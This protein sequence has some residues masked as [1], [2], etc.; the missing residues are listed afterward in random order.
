[1]EA[2]SPIFATKPV[3]ALELSQVRAELFRLL[4]LFLASEGLSKLIEERN[5]DLTHGS[6]AYLRDE[7]QRQEAMRLLLGTAGTI[8]ILYHDWMATQKNRL[9]D[10]DYIAGQLYRDAKSDAKPEPL[11]LR[12]ACN[13]LLHAD[14]VHFDLAN[15]DDWPRHFLKPIVYLYGTQNGCEWKAALNVIDYVEQAAN[16][17]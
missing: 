4:A 16:V 11:T 12:E 10:Q 2:R 8:R 1:M 5:H 13:K 14:K 6:F 15:E 3:H 9:T 17:C 7:F